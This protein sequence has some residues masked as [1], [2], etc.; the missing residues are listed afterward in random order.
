MAHPDSDPSIHNEPHLR[1]A[2]FEVDPSELKAARSLAQDSQE[3]DP[4]AAVEHTVWDEPALS[5]ELTED[6][7]GPQLK[8]SEWLAWRLKT[9]SVRRTW[10]VTILIVLAAGPWAVL[11][12]LVRGIAGGGWGLAMVVLIA[13]VTEEVMKVAATLWVVEKRPYWF[14]SPVQIMICSIAGGLAFAAIENVLYLFVYFPD[15]DP[16]LTV[17]RW[18]VCVG[19]HTVC[20]AL[21][22]IGL[23]RIWSRAISSRRRPQIS[24]GVRWGLAAILIHGLYNGTATLVEILL[25]LKF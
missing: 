17:V 6:H 15:A 25:P 13:P 2:S 1:A 14:R 7:D 12:A 16:W 20:S 3:S 5:A 8:Y 24:D 23:V 11:G 21:A 9:T 10:T 19:L 18:T 4:D 22:G